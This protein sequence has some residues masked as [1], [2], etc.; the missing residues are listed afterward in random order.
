MW[1]HPYSNTYN[2]ILQRHSNNSA[3]NKQQR[4][5]YTYG[6]EFYKWIQK[7]LEHFYRFSNNDTILFT[8]STKG[9]KQ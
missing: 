2:Q 6:R 5:T 8:G 1:P 9:V 4:K 7:Y 3:D